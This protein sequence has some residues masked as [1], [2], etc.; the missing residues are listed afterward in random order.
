MPHIVEATHSPSGS[1]RR[2]NAG[3]SRQPGVEQPVVGPGER[4]QVGAVEIERGERG[5]L[6][7]GAEQDRVVQVGQ[8]QRSG[9][10]WKNAMDYMNAGKIGDLRKVNVWG[11][12]N[13]GIG[14]M[15]APDEA[16]PAGVDFDMWLGPA[17]Q[18]SF[19]KTRFHGSCRMFCWNWQTGNIPQRSCSAYC[20]SALRWR[21]SISYMR[22]GSR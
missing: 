5:E 22:V 15:K 6:P 16:I 4:L 3:C 19:N 7:V 18:R 21:C 9:A 2:A 13:Y 8:Q 12:F 20:W 1:W 10:H 14:P 17:P 11:N